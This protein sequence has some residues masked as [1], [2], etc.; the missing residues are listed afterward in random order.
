MNTSTVEDIMGDKLSG[1]A[2]SPHLECWAILCNE[3]A[4][5]EG[6]ADIFVDVIAASGDRPFRDERVLVAGKDGILIGRVDKPIFVNW[7]SCM[8]IEVVRI[9][10]V[11][12]G[13]N[14]E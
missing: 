1:V 6:P 14:V 8:A 5:H 13:D 2:Y 3:I 12:N 11:D 9:T 10:P 7:R 4:H